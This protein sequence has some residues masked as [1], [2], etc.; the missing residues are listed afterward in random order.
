MAPIYQVRLMFNW[1]GGCLWCDNEI[2]RST[3]CVGPIED[4]LPLSEATKRELSEMSIWHDQSLNQDYPPDP[5]PWD[6]EEINRFDA[7]AHSMMQRLRDELGPD[8]EIVYQPL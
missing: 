1:Y 7:A 8:F 5:G 3:F 4:V 2:T 6:K